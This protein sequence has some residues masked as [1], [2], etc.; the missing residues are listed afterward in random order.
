MTVGRRSLGASARTGAHGTL[1]RVRRVQSGHSDDAAVVA[2]LV[3]LDPRRPWPG[4]PRDPAV[5]QRGLDAMVGP[6]WTDADPPPNA[7]PSVVLAPA[8]LT[9]ADDPGAVLAL[10]LDVVPVGGHVVTEEPGSGSTAE[11]EP[12]V[13]DGE[14]AGLVS[15]VDSHDADGTP[16]LDL[17]VMWFTGEPGAVAD[18][19]VDRARVVPMSAAEHD[20]IA[21]VNG[22]EL[23][24][25]WSDWAGR[26]AGDGWRISIH[27]RVT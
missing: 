27:R 26:P 11:L 20:A 2:D 8:A 6:G 19:R 3:R 15:V 7:A 22:F 13:V 12:L 18:V 17:A 21:A 23:V 10:L 4:V 1:G 16:V 5:R 14:R 9:V 25:R 24:A